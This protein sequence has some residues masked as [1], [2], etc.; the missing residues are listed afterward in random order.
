MSWQ[1]LYE[2]YELYG[3]NS[4]IWKDYSTNKFSATITDVFNTIKNIDIEKLQSGIE[5]THARGPS[6]RKDH[7]KEH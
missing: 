7:S 1:S 3:E 5:S 2:L 6:Y 4:D